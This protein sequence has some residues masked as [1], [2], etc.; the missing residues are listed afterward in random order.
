MTDHF[1]TTN[2]TNM[3]DQPMIDAAFCLANMRNRLLRSP[4]DTEISKGVP[5]NFRVK[6][7]RRNSGR[8]DKEYFSDNGNQFR[9]IEAVKR[10][11]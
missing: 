2:T 8:M 1:I 11:I 10:S 7:I 5:I 6:E 4:T 3:T 9:S